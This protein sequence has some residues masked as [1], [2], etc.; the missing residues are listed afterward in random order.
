MPME[1]RISARCRET[2]AVS[3]TTRLPPLAPAALPASAVATTACGGCAVINDPWCVTSCISDGS[4]P[5]QAGGLC[6]GTSPS[7]MRKQQA[8]HS[9]WFTNARA[10]LLWNVVLC[11][12]VQFD[13]MYCYIMRHA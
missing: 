2:H 13:S 3:A 6:S 7:V 1:Q 10:V 12:Q 9:A 5:G 8:M 4:Q 11:A